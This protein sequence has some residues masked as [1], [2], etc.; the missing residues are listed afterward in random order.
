LSR[1]KYKKSEKYLFS[2]I[3]KKNNILDGACHSPQLGGKKHEDD[4]ESPANLNR[5]KQTE[6]AFQEII[7]LS[8]S[9]ETIRI[10]GKIHVIG[11]IP[12]AT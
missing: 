8:K 12:P 6:Q 10:I 3:Y 9:K 7:L 11:F 2:C 1:E 4:K 5:I